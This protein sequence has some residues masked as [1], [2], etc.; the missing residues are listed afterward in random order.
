MGL[1][2]ANNFGMNINGSKFDQHTTKKKWK[3]E[4]WGKQ[5]TMTFQHADEALNLK[6]TAR[7]TLMN[8]PR[9][10]RP[11]SK[12]LIS[13]LQM[14][15]NAKIDNSFL[16]KRIRQLSGGQKQR[17]NLLRALLLETPILILDEPL[18]GL[19]FNSIKRIIDLLIQRKVH[20]T[21]ILIIS[22]NEEIIET[23]VDNA[24]IYYLAQV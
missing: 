11:K 15:F 19:D 5:I 4:L 16:K 1:I 7:Q 12:E 6:S 21:G 3:K 22:H 20:G 14:V 17:L 10:K 13:K 18:N 8:L 2:R 24:A 23:I 9:K